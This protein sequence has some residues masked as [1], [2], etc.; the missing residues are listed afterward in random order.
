MNRDAL[1]QMI[2]DKGIKKNFISKSL[3]IS[4]QALRNKL[5]GG[6]LSG[7]FPFQARVAACFSAL[8]NPVVADVVDIVDVAVAQNELGT[9]P[10]VAGD[11]SS[12]HIPASCRT[13]AASALRY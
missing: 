5:N 8:D 4:D 3:D 1:E 12:R 13:A 9:H 7:L 2:K 6:C 11:M 10:V